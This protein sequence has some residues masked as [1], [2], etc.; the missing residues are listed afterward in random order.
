MPG[1]PRLADVDFLDVTVR[2]E[3]MNNVPGQETFFLLC[4]GGAYQGKAFWNNKTG[5]QPIQIQL[6][7]VPCYALTLVLYCV[8]TFLYQRKQAPRDTATRT[9]KHSCI[10]ARQLAYTAPVDAREH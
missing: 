5:R 3:S 1:T 6:G 8:H 9:R 7:V 4:V 2:Q 10:H